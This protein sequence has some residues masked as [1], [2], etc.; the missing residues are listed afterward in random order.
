M[1]T[2]NHPPGTSRTGERGV[3][4]VSD[5]RGLAG[6][7]HRWMRVSASG[8]SRCVGRASGLRFGQASD[9]SDVSGNGCAACERARRT[10]WQA[11][12][13]REFALD[14]E[15]LHD[16]GATYRVCYS[17][18]TGRQTI[19]DYSRLTQ[20]CRSMSVFPR[21][22][23]RGPDARLNRAH[24]PPAR[25]RHERRTGLRPDIIGCSQSRRSQVSNSRPYS[26]AY[27]RSR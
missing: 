26:N 23:T 22:R 24:H 8:R 20:A 6:A 27:L 1:F 18:A 3:G 5:M 16:I 15:N 25:H 9:F 19:L 2:R 14:A 4:H 7:S 11:A 13:A 12:V 21:K 17:N 10:Q